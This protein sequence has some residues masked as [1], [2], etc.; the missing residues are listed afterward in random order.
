MIVFTF[1]FN[2]DC[3]HSFLVIVLYS[4]LIIRNI[5]S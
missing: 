3:S 4:F 5:N 1:V 2:S